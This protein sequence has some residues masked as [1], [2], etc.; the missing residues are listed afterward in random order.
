ELMKIQVISVPFLLAGMEIGSRL[1]AKM[2]QRL[3]MMITYVLLF[4]SGISLLAK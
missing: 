3:F 2:S 4:I 1:Y